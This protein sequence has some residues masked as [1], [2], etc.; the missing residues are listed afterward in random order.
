MKKIFLLIAVVLGF[1]ATKV[2][3]QQRQV[4]YVG[5]PQTYSGSVGQS[6]V[7]FGIK[8][9]GNLANWEGE[10]MTSVQDLIDYTDGSVSRKMREGFH[11]GGYVTIPVMKG[12]EIEPG[13]QYSQKGMQ[14]VGKI[15]MEKADF[16]N[17][18][19]TL[20]N[21]AEYLDLPVIAKVYVGE[22][23]HIF[24]GPQVSYLVSNKVQAKAG[25]LGYNALNREWDMKS[26]L[27]DVDVAVTGGL[28]YQFANGFNI[29]AGYDY[30]LS[31]IDDNG[32]FD[33]FNR[34]AKASIGYT[35]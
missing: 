11:I 30:G 34:V 13:L 31:T 6:P 33:T 22:G 14:M 28:G 21:K 9:G 10:T 32:S 4:R 12:F 24:A 35:F 7:R 25:A 17:A 3:A 19:V 15:P 29:S 20:T 16:L 1:V 8:A 18:T 23:F 5:Q 2:Q 26:G 27:R